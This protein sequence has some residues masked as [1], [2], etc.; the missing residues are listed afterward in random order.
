MSTG[1]AMSLYKYIKKLDNYHGR[2]FYKYWQSKWIQIDGG[3]KWKNNVAKVCF[4]D[5]EVFDNYVKECG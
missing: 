4:P 5:F 1:A 2:H 3:K